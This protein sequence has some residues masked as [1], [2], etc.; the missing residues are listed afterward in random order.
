[1]VD[2]VLGSLDCYLAEGSCRP[3]FPK[4][5]PQN[6]EGLGDPQVASK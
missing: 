4:D 3:F 6:W 5:A 1:M 2:V